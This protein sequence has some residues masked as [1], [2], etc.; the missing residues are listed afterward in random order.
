M[1]AQGTDALSRGITMTG[2]MAGME[3]SLFVPLHQSVQDRQDPAFIHDWIRAWA[4]DSNWLSPEEWFKPQAVLAPC[5]WAPPPAAADVALDQLGKWIHMHPSNTTHIVVIPRLMTSR[6]H[7]IL[8]KIC[9]LIFTIPTETDLWAHSQFEPLLVGIALPLCRHKPW[10]L[11]GTPLLESVERV[12][13]DMPEA[14]CGWGGECFAPTSPHN[15]VIGHHAGKHGV[16]YVTLLLTMENSKWP[17]LWMLRVRV[18]LMG[19]IKRGIWKGEM[20]ITW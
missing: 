7:K 17:C 10:R 13:R 2:V 9:D 14:T 18:S 3:F 1:I 5:I 8:G 15:E 12:L 4:G 6:W 19:R 16:E 11:R 20:V